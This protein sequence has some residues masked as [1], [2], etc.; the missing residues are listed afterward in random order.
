MS[1]HR[2]HPPSLLKLAERTIAEHALLP[3]GSRV[4]C[5][6]SGGPDSTAL[7]HVLARLRPRFGH[8]VVAHGV[9]HGLRPE[10]HDELAIAAELAAKL[11]VPFSV[12]R[13]EV[14]AGGNLQA[15]ARA[16]RWA[17]LE[18]AASSAG[19]VLIA[20]GHTADD[21]AET[22]LIRLLRGAGP[23]GL[24]VLGPRSTPEERP[25]RLRPLI[26]ARR[27]DVLVHLARHAIRFA[28]DPSN[29][30]LRF[31]RSRVRHEILPALEA[32]SPSIVSHLCALSGMLAD[33]VP[34]DDPLGGLGR[35]QRLAV[36][37]ALRLGRTGLTLRGEAGQPLDVT[38]PR[39]RPMVKRDR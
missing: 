38:F 1:A 7:L 24:A 36:A 23:R 27:S 39:G 8:D 32:L 13:V 25:A 5:A 4:L 35:A 14:A 20:T 33:L 29:R 19:A 2:S 17:A 3:R 21:R 12:T 37:R 22:V 34:S 26:A 30:D 31:V 9:D 6:C 11:E 16:A 10:A 15:R 18:V 28:E